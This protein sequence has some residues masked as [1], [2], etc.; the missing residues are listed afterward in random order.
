M[1]TFK[2]GTV[3][4]NMLIC[5]VFTI[6]NTCLSDPKR[7]QRLPV[8]THGWIH[9]F[10]VDFTAVAKRVFVQ[11]YMYVT[12]IFIPLKSSHFHV[13]VLHKHSI[14]KKKPSWRRL[15]TLGQKQ[16]SA[17]DVGENSLMNKFIRIEWVSEWVSEW[18]GKDCLLAS[19]NDYAVHEQKTAANCLIPSV[20]TFDMILPNITITYIALINWAGGLYG[21]TV[22]EVVSTDRTQG[23][24]YRRPRS[25]FFHTDGLSSVNNKM[26][27]I[28][29]RWKL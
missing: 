18:V 28:W 27:I 26:F 24:L 12:C 23:V 29:Q 14:W 20:L 10:Q 17:G 2:Y 5:F 11:N 4:R 21:R 3:H 1:I 19:W 22:T 7:N 6:A 16:Y 25:S 15:N 9:Q 13:N 8:P